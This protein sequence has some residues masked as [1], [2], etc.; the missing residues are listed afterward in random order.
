MVG[1]GTVFEL[2]SLTR[3]LDLDASLLAPTSR[4]QRWK[5][6]KIK[7][8]CRDAFQRAIAEM[9]T[10]AEGVAHET[11]EISSAPIQGQDSADVDISSAPTQEQG[12]ADVDINFTS[13][14]RQGSAD[15][16]MPA[17]AEQ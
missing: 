8:Q 2:S 1:V 7:K 4:H 14:Q 11:E 13:I 3:P 16:D 10:D 12:S 5:T 6:N 9:E 15:V 17:S